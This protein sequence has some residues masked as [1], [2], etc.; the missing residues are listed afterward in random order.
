MISKDH[1]LRVLLR[2]LEPQA[3]A[4]KMTSEDSWEILLELNSLQDL[5]PGNHPLLA[6]AA[7]IKQSRADAIKNL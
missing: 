5:L 6:V 2:T 3:G 4:V 1:P 7:A